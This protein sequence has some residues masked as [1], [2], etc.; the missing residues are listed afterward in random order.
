VARLRVGTRREGCFTKSGH[1]T[2]H[3]HDNE[4]DIANG[5]GPWPGYRKHQ[6]EELS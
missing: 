5:E 3:E 2:D 1:V 6:H 4:A